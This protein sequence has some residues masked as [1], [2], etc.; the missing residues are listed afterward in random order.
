MA[1][2]IIS[3]NRNTEATCECGSICEKVS[4]DVVNDQGDVFTYGSSCI[5]SVLGLDVS[6]HEK[7]G[8]QYLTLNI[9]KTFPENNAYMAY[10]KDLVIFNNLDTN[11]IIYKVVA[12]KVYAWSSDNSS[13]NLNLNKGTIYYRVKAN[14]KQFITMSKIQSLEIGSLIGEKELK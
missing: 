9:I 6:E 10:H 1:Y 11:N 2:T 13:L 5:K 3:I 7:R 4:Y 8:I 14:K 12:K